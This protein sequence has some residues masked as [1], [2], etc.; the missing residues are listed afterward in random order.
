[1][2]VVP[3]PQKVISRQ[4]PPSVQSMSAK[5]ACAHVEPMQLK[6]AAQS[7]EYWQGPC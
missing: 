1:V 5:H 7:L 3:E 6:P 4:D 2:G